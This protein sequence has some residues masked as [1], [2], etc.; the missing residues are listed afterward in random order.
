MNYRK[1]RDLLSAMFWWAALL[2]T[3]GFWYA[4]FR[5]FVAPAFAHEAIPTAAN[6]LGW[7][8][9]WECC[10]SIDCARV[11]KRNVTEGPE[12]V[13]IRL[14]KGDHPMLLWDAQTTIPYSSRQLRVRK[15]G[16]FHVCHDR[17]F[18]KPDGSKYEGKFLCVYLPPRGF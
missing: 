15:D 10:S 3:I 8:Y 17:Q 4:V 11:D 7:R 13:T 12:G 9:D 6:P 16:D 14:A 1:R 5:L 18:I 2:F